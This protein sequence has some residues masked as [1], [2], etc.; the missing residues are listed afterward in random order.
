MNS[1][2]HNNQSASE[3]L[4]NAI[5]TA[6]EEAR[7]A[8]SNSGDTSTECAVAWDI[9][10]EMQAESSHRKAN[11]RKNSLESYCESNPDALECLV[12]DV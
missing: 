8:C 5:S 3:A 6:V 4:A 2:I 7:A 1:S 12:Y 9:V 11:I 10:E